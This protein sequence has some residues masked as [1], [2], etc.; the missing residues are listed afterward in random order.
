MS[1]K[2]YFHVKLIVIYFLKAIQQGLNIDPSS[3]NTFEP[4]TTN[5]QYLE[6]QSEDIDS[7]FQ[8]KDYRKALFHI[9]QSLNIALASKRLKVK[10]AECL[11][12]L[13]NYQIGVSCCACSFVYI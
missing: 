8:A 2:A 11:A 6:K 3:K 10:K 4:E 7:A 12:Y 1:L 9:E 5:C 13:G